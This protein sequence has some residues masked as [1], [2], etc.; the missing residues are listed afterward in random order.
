MAKSW[1]QSSHEWFR[2][3]KRGAKEAL[4]SLPPHED[5]MHAEQ[6]EDEPSPDPESVGT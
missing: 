3:L 6:E 1:E 5:N 2:V 4:S